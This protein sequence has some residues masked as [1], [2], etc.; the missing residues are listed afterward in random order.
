MNKICSILSLFFLASFNLSAQS[1]D[2]EM[3][4]LM[5]EN[6]KI[7]VVVGVIFLIFS[8]LFIYL[9]RIDSKLRKLEKERKEI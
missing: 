4:D 9:F 1:Q 5:R 8:V 2:V 7:Y 6:G 3:A